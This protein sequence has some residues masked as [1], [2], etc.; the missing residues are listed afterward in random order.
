VK[1]A[2]WAN[3]YAAAL[4]LDITAIAALSGI[5]VAIY[6][7]DGPVER[8]DLLVHFWLC[9]AYSFLMMSSF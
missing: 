5:A 3:K 2:V 7:E 1:Y 8:F 9:S 6:I 4:L